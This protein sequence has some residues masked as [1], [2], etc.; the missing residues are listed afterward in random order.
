MSADMP[1]RRVGRRPP[2][3]IISVEGYNLV[4][5]D[6]QNH[7]LCECEM[8][9]NEWPHASECTQQSLFGV[10]ASQMH[11]ICDDVAGNVGGRASNSADIGQHRR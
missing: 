8:P 7:L 11:N 3:I 1:R 9:P 6:A 10:V 4:V 2:L 5:P